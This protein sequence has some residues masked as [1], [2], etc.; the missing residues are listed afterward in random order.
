MGKSRECLDDMTDDL[1]RAALEKG[2]PDNVT[3]VLVKIG[4]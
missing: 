3:V 2:G 4:G 1:V